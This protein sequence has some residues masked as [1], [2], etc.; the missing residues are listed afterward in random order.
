M[1]Q[2]RTAAL[3]ILVFTVLCA[4]QPGAAPSAVPTVGAADPSPAPPEPTQAPEASGTPPDADNAALQSPLAPGDGE[5]GSED[6][7]LLSPLPTPDSTLHPL[8]V[9]APSSDDVGVVTGYLLGGDPPL[10]V[11]WGILYLGNVVAAEDGSPLMVA[12]DRA[13]APETVVQAGGQFKV[14]S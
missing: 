4:C 2:A 10:P 11:T 3:L 9:P 13:T 1:I 12:T 7:A 6:S 8:E 14:R 5:S